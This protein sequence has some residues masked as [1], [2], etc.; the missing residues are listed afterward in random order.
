MLKRSSVKDYLIVKNYLDVDEV[1]GERELLAV[2]H[3]VVVAVSQSPDLAFMVYK[4]LCTCLYISFYGR[5]DRFIGKFYFQQ[6]LR[7]KK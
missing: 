3:P 7:D 6:G 1:H 5:T 2:E 4:H